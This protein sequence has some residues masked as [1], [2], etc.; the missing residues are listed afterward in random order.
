MK[1]F[2][3]GIRA[4]AGNAFTPFE[5]PQPHLDPLERRPNCYLPTNNPDPTSK[6][7]KKLFL[8]DWLTAASHVQSLTLT[9]SKCV[10]IDD[11]VY[12]ISDEISTAEKLLRDD[13]DGCSAREATPIP[14][15]A[16]TSSAYPLF[17][18]LREA[19]VVEFQ[20]SDVTSFHVDSV[21]TVMKALLGG[22]ALKVRPNA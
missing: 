11:L 7:L 4:D 16:T 10:K 2:E 5:T 9:G 3:L 18:K 21:M 22:G 15:P 6:Q 1:P 14:A 17:D 13:E 19:R 12:R 8:E 20:I